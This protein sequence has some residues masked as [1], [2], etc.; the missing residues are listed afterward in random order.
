MVIV[1]VVDVGVFAS[2]GGSDSGGALSSWFHLHHN[3]GE[4]GNPAETVN[5]AVRMKKQEK[6]NTASYSNKVMVAVKA[7][8][9]IP[10][11]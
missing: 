6:I 5:S 9:S 2:G 11:V 4:R 7:F 1:V 10:F 3:V 8:P